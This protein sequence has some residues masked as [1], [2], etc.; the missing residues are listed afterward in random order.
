[1]SPLNALDWHRLAF[2][3]GATGAALA[4]FGARGEH[5]AVTWLLD[6]MEL[7]LMGIE[8]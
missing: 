3:V 1:M 4:A 7:R 8:P 5:P 2:S 6:A